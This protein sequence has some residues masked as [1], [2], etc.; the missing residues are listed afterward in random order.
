[1]PYFLFA[2][3]GTRRGILNFG[4]LAR[5]RLKFAFLIDLSDSVPPSLKGKG[6][7]GKG[8]IVRNLPTIPTRIQFFATC[9]TTLDSAARNG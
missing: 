9:Q 2:S 8:S 1:M 5:F 6:D 3:F 4:F 7:R